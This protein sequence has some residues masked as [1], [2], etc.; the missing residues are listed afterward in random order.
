MKQDMD[1]R[2]IGWYLLLVFGLSAVWTLPLFFLR[3]EENSPILMAS[4]MGFMVLPALSAM[5]VKHRTKDDS[6]LFLRLSLK[7]HWRL[8]AMAAFV[9]GLGIVFGA[10]LYFLRFPEQLDLSLGYARAFLEASGQVAEV[11]SLTLPMVAGLA[12]VAVIAA[13]LVIINHVFAFGEELG[14]RGYLLPKLCRKLG[15][16]KAI[17]LDGALWGLVHAP[18]VCFGLNYTG[19]YPGRPW[20]GILMMVVFA[21]ALGIFCSYLTLKTQS[22]YPACIAHGALNA[23][24]ELPL[25]FCQ[26]DYNALLGPKPSGIVGMAGLLL[27]DIFLMRSLRKQSA[28]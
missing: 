27:L 2:R 20:A 12:A 7:Q 4:G 19:N 24:R 25:F 9:P 3:P 10:V 23:I 13:P 21:T 6:S 11:P 1:S 18:L 15:V 8:Y 17:V 14:W 22:I 26:P 28:P 5:L 16:P